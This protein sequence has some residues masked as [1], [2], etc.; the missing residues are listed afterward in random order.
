MSA[1]GISHLANKRQR[2]EQKL[3]LAK[4]KRAADGRRATLKKGNLPTLYAS[5]GDNNTANRKLL[6]D[7]STPLTPGRPWQ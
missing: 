5:G 1:N 7:G 4:I 3:A 2:Q 6:Q